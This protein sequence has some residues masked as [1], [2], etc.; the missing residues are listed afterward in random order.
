MGCGLIYKSQMMRDE[1][2]KMSIFRDRNTGFQIQMLPVHIN[3]EA[4]GGPQVI[5]E[6]VG[7]IDKVHW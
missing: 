1:Q 4:L 7:I 6:L 2:M 5:K 3:K